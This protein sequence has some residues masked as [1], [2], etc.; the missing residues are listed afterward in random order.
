MKKIVLVFVSIFFAIVAVAQAEVKITIYTEDWAPYNFKINEKFVG[1]STEIVEAT[2]KRA[3]VNYEMIMAS[4]ARGYRT[5]LYENN[6]MLFTTARTEEREPLF[7]WVGPIATRNVHLLKLKERK[8]ISISSLEGVK[9]FHLGVLRDDA[10]TQ[11]FIE[12]GFIEN[13]HFELISLA[14]VEIKML[15]AGRYDLI[16]GDEIAA[17]YQAKSYGYDPSQIEKAFL[18]IDRGG[19]YMAFNKG[20]DSELVKKIENTF[21]QLTREGLLD[22]IKEKYLK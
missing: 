19:Y 1:I 20:T 15:Y 8:D 12:K 11:Y 22:H 2:F 5:V 10:S 7:A 17:K 3:N 16:P 4:W 9:K 13:K 21:L 18:L 14:E 6:T